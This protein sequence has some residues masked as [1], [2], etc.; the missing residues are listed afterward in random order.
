M[1]KILDRLTVTVI[2]TRIHCHITLWKE[3]NILSTHE[4]DEQSIDIESPRKNGGRYIHIH[5]QLC[6]RLYPSSQGALQS[7]YATK[8]PRSVFKENSR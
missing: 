2:N 6:H 7:R 4:Y 3:T 8:L 5:S 1:E